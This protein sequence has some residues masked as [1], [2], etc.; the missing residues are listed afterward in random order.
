MLTFVT[1]YF[2]IYTYDN[3]M[4]GVASQY[5]IQFFRLGDDGNTV[6]LLMKDGTRHNTLIFLDD[7]KYDLFIFI[8]LKDKN[9]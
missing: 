6:T 5:L 4:N 2:P 7:G 3:D 8:G 9:L 1:A